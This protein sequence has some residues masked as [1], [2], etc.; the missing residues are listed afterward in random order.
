MNMKCLWCGGKF[1]EL[2]EDGTHDLN[3]SRELMKHSEST[4]VILRRIMKESSSVDDAPSSLSS[5][6]SKQSL[7][8][9]VEA[10]AKAKSKDKS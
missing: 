5:S 6:P 9:R 7:K 10:K 8:D 1:V 2:Q 4:K 3:C